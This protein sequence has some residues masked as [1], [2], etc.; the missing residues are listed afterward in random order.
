MNGLKTVFKFLYFLLLDS[1]S[2]NH[3]KETAD[4][5]IL[6]FI[7][8]RDSSEVPQMRAEFSCALDVAVAEL[9]EFECID[10]TECS[11]YDGFKVSKKKSKKTKTK[12]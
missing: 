1:F 8:R 10:S 5:P 12:K 4:D 2:F 11:L 7:L 6:R 9:E 3:I